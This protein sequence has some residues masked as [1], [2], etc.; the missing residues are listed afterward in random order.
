MIMKLSHLALGV[1]LLPL[2]FACDLAGTM[3]VVPTALIM[4]MQSRLNVAATRLYEVAAAH[5]Q[6][7]RL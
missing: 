4:W 7:G 3:S 6:R 2:A 5:I 1:A